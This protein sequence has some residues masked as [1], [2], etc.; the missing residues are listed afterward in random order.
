ME[1]KGGSG[2][3][4]TIERLKRKKRKLGPEKKSKRKRRVI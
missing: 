4:K 3:A 1:E 2:Y